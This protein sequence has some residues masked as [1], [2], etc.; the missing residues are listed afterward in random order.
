[1]K[2]FECEHFTDSIIYLL[3]QTAVYCRTKGSKFFEDLNIGL[4]L[5]QYITLDAISFNQGIC[6]RELSKL[7]LKDRSYTSRILNSLEESN[8]IER[9]IETKGKRLVKRLYLT[10]NG[11]L[12]ISNNQD[13]LKN[14]YLQAFETISEEEFETIRNLLEKMKNCISKYTIMS[15]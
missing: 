8:L 13:K 3:E 14:S 5:D 10:Q 4:S 7:I 6:Q 15:I 12:I 11:E 1:M 9:R 2:E